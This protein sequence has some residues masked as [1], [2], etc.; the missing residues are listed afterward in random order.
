M[1]RSYKKYPIIRQE[2]EDYR[3]LNR[4]LRYDKFAEFP[5]G[6]SFKKH[7]PH[8]YTWA[9]RWTREQAISSYYERR[10]Q[11]KRD[12]PTLE[13]WLNYWESCCIRK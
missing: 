6:S 12:F 11:M 3:H 13:E 4:Q 8:W 2:K 5:K 1:S 9:Y 10:K 7:K